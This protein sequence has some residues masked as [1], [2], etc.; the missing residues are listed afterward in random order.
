M[1]EHTPGPWTVSADR[2]AW[3]FYMLH[4]VASHECDECDECDDAIES[5]CPRCG[6]ERD[7]ANARLIAAAPD[8]LEALEMLLDTKRM[9]PL[10]VAQAQARAAITKARGEG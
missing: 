8:L 6:W 3:G 10:R 1:T 7:D 5:H 9:A 4:D 2:D